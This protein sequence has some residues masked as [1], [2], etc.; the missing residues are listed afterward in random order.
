MRRD[1]RQRLQESEQAFTLRNHQRR[2]LFQLVVMIEQHFCG[3]LLQH[4]DVKRPAHFVDG[5]NPFRCAENVAEAH[6]RETDFGQRAHD[7]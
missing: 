1:I 2:V 7:E 3:H 4:A 6:A 5:V